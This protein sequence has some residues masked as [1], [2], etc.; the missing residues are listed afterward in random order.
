MG[1]F[2]LPIDIDI[3]FVLIGYITNKETKWQQQ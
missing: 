1:A 3:I 2:L